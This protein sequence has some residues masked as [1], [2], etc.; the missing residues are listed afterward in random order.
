MFK[1]G[2][3]KFTKKTLP[4]NF[5]DQ[6]LNLEMEIELNEQVQ[7]ELIQDLISLY[8]EGVEYY[9]SIKDR[10]HLYFQRKLNAL[11]LKPTFIN[12]TQKFEESHKP[13]DD[14]QVKRA[15][16]QEQTR[17]IELDLIYSQTESKEAQVK[18]IVDNH[19]NQVMKIESLIKNE[20]ANQSDV[21]QMRLERRRRS[22]LTHSLSQPEIDLQ[23][24]KSGN[25]NKKKQIELHEQIGIRNSI[26]FQVQIKQIIHEEDE[27]AANKKDS[28]LQ[29]TKEKKW[30]IIHQASL[31]QENK[32]R[33]NSLIQ[34]RRSL[35]L[36]TKQMIQIKRSLSCG[37]QEPVEGLKNE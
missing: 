22:K 5:A 16:F 6:I 11:M 23:S 1:F 29:Q 31:N 30:E 27:T 13:Q 21:L 32:K 33:T 3:E 26:S 19:T 37:A 24:Q 14:N 7:I 10:R 17:R 8:M 9:E 2:Q 20:I 12:A 36:T 34:R 4:K 18:G 35:F 25:S 15:K 28:T